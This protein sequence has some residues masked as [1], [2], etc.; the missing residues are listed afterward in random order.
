MRFFIQFL[1]EVYSMWNVTLLVEIVSTRKE[2]TGSLLFFEFTGTFFSLKIWIPFWLESFPSV[3]FLVISFSSC[4]CFL[5]L[6]GWLTLLFTWTL[7][8]FAFSFCLDLSSC[9]FLPL[10]AM[11]PSFSVSIWTVERYAVKVNGTCN[12]R[13]E[14]HLKLMI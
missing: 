6:S 12:E 3:S 10:V 13:I 8:S 7:L 1:I 4:F 11:S 2:S 5:T 9:E 14:V